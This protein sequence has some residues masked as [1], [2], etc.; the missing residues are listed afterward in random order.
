MRPSNKKCKNGMQTK[1]CGP[2]ENKTKNVEKIISFGLLSS[3]SMC[4]SFSLS[5]SESS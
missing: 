2:I 4:Y 1:T 5:S 3:V